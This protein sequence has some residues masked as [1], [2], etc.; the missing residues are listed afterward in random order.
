MRVELDETDLLLL[1]RRGM[2]IPVEELEG[3]KECVLESGARIYRSNVHSGV[4]ELQGYA[5]DKWDIWK[6]VDL[7]KE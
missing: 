3:Q 2:S 4:W 5:Q 7:L 1:R 6:V